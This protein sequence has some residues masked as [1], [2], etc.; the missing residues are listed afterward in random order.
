[1]LCTYNLNYIMLYLSRM[2]MIAFEW[3]L[4]TCPVYE[5]IN[6]SEIFQCHLLD[7]CLLQVI[8]KLIH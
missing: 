4:L 6:K 7:S 3:K 1:M 2:K 8:E 5:I